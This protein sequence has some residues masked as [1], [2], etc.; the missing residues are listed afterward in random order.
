MGKII[1]LTE[2]DII[3]AVY[4]IISEQSEFTDFDNTYNYKL[5]NNHWY[6]K[7]KT[8]TSDKWFDI[9]NIPDAV[10]KLNSRYGTDVE[11]TEPKSNPITPIITKPKPGVKLPIQ[12]INPSVSDK[13]GMV[14]PINQTLKPLAPDGASVN[15][16]KLNPQSI[17]PASAESVS[18]AKPT[19]SPLPARAK[20]RVMLDKKSPKPQDVSA[21]T[22]QVNIPN[23]VKMIVNEKKSNPKFKTFDGKYYILSKENSTMYVFNNNHRLIDQAVVGRGRV[24]GDF[25]NASNPD[26]DFAGSHATTPAGSGVFGNVENDPSYGGNVADIKFNNPRLGDGLAMHPIYPPEFAKRNAI[27]QD[28]VQVDKLMSFGCINVPKEILERPTFGVNSGDSIFITKEPARLQSQALANA[29]KARGNNDITMNGPIRE[30][31][32]KIIRVTES[33]LAVI[34]KKIISG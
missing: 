29:R 1:K 31:V 24:I 34:I 5:D 30:N 12:A 3:S 28:P 18:M 21:L 14:K 15:P 22:N 27:L 9:T 11:T 17:N 26:S 13:T 23:D 16:I 4:Q 20:P 8:S 33:Q 2:S 6:A 10:N 19:K 25:P 7:R 32:K